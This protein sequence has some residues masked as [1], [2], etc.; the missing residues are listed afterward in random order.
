MPPGGI[1]SPGVPE[2]VSEGGVQE[3]VIEAPFPA[4]ATEQARSLRQW[5]SHHALDTAPLA[6]P[7]YRRLLIGQGTSFIGSMLTQV[8][9][10]VQVYSLTHSSFYVGL[11]GLAGLIPI[12]AFGLYGGAIA[13]VIDRRTLYLWS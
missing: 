12:V 10:P 11:V 9:V 7:T 1:N 5:L 13:D 4:E 8:A 2:R 3:A 6:I